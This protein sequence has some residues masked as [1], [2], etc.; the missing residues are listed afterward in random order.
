M[1]EEG[2]IIVTCNNCCLLL[3]FLIGMIGGY[4]VT[5]ICNTSV[6]I[7][8]SWNEYEKGYSAGISIWYF[9][10]FRQ[11]VIRLTPSFLAALD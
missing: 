10:M 2:K 4:N 6:S 1:S 8:E 7:V 9:L 3:K 5:Y 11:I